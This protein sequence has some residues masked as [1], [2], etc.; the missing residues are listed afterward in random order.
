MAK[1]ELLR[2]LDRR[3]PLTIVR[4]P[5]GYGKTSLV[6][7]WARSLSGTP[8]VVWV[9]CRMALFGEGSVP[10]V[11]DAIAE[12]LARSG[13]TDERASDENEARAQLAAVLRELHRP[14]C[15]VLD[16]FHHVADAGVE[17][18]LVDLVRKF[19]SLSVI[20]C[21][22]RVVSIETVGAATIDSVVIRPAD[23]LLTEG[24]TSEIARRLGHELAPDE[25]RALHVESGGWPALVR[26][27]LSNGGAA[28]AR[29][30]LGTLDLRAGDPFLRSV[31]QELDDWQLQRFIVRTAI[32]DEFSED[33][34]R[35]C[36]GI[37][38]VGE[39]LAHLVAAGVVIVAGTG[40]KAVYHYVPAVR[41]ACAA[42]LTSL[43]PRQLAVASRRAAEVCVAHRRTN[44]ALGHLVRSESWTEVAQLI[45]S[46][47]VELVAEFPE[48][49]AEAVE[50]IPTEFLE[51][52]ARLVIARDHLLPV[53]RKDAAVD[54]GDG[55][56]PTFAPAAVG[57][58]VPRDDGDLFELPGI[59]DAMEQSL[60]QIAL[61]RMTGNFYAAKEIADRDHDA[62]LVRVDE[63]HDEVRQ[64]LAPVL[65][66]WAMTRLL[67]ADLPGALIAFREA[68][69]LATTH[70][71]PEIVREASVGAA[72]ACAMLGYLQ[73]AEEWL[74]AAE[75][76]CLPT[77]R[78]SPSDQIVEA[79]R[80]IVAL[81]RVEPAGFHAARSF[82][83]PQDV[84]ELWALA[85][86]IRAQVALV[87]GTHFQILGEIEAARGHSD[88]EGAPGLG[89]ALLVAASVDLHLALG[90]IS[91]ARLAINAV[92]QR[93]ET[94][95]LARA[96]TEYLS[97]EFV[98]AS[99]VALEWLRT[100]IYAPRHRLDFLVI[101]A[102]AE[103]A[104]GRRY[105]AAVAL[106]EAV[107]ISVAT[108]ITR[109][110]L[111]VPRRALLDLEVEVPKIR[112]ILEQPGLLEMAEFFPAPTISA[113][114]SDRERQVLESLSR[115]SSLAG[116]ARSL[117]LSSNT[118]KTHLRSIYRK[119]GTHSSVETVERAFELGLIERPS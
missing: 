76:D 93:Y 104:R 60:A 38:D 79:V 43:D 74:A 8:D 25:V 19:E 58:P 13:L 30:T 85:V 98:R 91:R 94:T 2:F 57:P 112:D 118:V 54:G 67:A 77:G 4:G 26:A 45:D 21:L 6:A 83:L 23:L 37:H 41:R 34:A 62:V 99:E 42:L 20:V 117:Y 53:V 59:V 49:V 113:Q 27:I 108:G 106:D 18:A 44:I 1:S 29:G 5:R 14:L 22:A 61:L 97:G 3:E 111:K 52:H 70:G 32:L 24:E 56:L 90:H 92:T 47:W 95:G 40:E 35:W 89:E 65:H 87:D 115:S 86:M 119:L 82:D 28:P 33:D 36:S 107:A 71:H 39:H 9:S 102:A 15:L 68:V 105:E 48:D 17:A 100:R 103:Q 96:R 116:V 72:L 64:E 16:D 66:E 55:T 69:E 75:R 51:C 73:P 31:W 12:A 84:G 110:F 7:H 63:L 10:T 81:E 88:G 50:R 114:L 101:L 11:W 109:A 78:P 46:R 80:G